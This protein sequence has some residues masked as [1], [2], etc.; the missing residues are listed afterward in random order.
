MWI[1]L[2]GFS[3]GC[4]LVAGLWLWFCYGGAKMAEAQE[5]AAGLDIEDSGGTTALDG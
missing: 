4:A 5:A 3:L 1:V 2:I